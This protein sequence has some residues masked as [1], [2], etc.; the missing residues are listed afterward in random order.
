MSGFLIDTHV[1]L[2]DITGS[3]RLVENH[4]R[5]M[6]GDGNK[7]VSIASLWEI[8]IKVSV[9]KLPMPD[10]LLDIIAK[11]DVEILP[12]LPEH[13]IAVSDLPHHHRDPFDRM[14]VAQAQLENLTIMT[15]DKHIRLY[16]VKTV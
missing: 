13:A 12:I 5:I 7:F 16:D 10:D 3:E 15:L 8:A 2:W 9:R 1:L 4:R 11:S 14:L 6:H